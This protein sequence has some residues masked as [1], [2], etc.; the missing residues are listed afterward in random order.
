[1]NTLK[2]RNSNLFSDIHLVLNPA[3]EGPIE[4]R[5]Q[6]FAYVTVWG[7]LGTKYSVL[8]TKTIPTENYEDKLKSL[9]LCMR[10]HCNILVTQLYSF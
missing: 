1:M 7:V 8:L 9:S 4:H 10:E 3:L 2:T 6:T 5:S